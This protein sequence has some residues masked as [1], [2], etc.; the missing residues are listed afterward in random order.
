M[1][2]V[3]AHLIAGA[4]GDQLWMSAII[5]D[6][7]TNGPFYSNEPTRMAAI[8]SVHGTVPALLVQLKNAEAVTEAHVAAMPPAIQAHK[9][10]YN[11]L[12]AWF[13]TFQTHTREHIAEITALIKAARS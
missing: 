12:A 8:A 4:Q 9:H 6:T 10:Q 5:D 3:L 11:L 13:T 2:E 1:K 7:D